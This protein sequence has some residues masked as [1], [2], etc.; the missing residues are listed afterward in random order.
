VLD[1]KNAS[2]GF[3]CFDCSFEKAACAAKALVKGAAASN[4]DCTVA[5]EMSA[6][7]LN[8]AS[9]ATVWAEEAGPVVFIGIETE[10]APRDGQQW[11]IIRNR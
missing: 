4:F 8:K 7:A 9:R 6:P 1:L 3:N 2:S 5:S 10:I 11:A